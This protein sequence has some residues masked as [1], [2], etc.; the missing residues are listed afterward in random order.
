MNEI[1]I[2][3]KEDI[4]KI[5]FLKDNVLIETYEENL[6][7]TMIEDNIYIGKVQNVFKGMQAAFVNIGVG[8]NVFI[9]LKDLLP[10]VDVVKNNVE[11]IDRPI[12][13][14]IR[15]GQPIIVQVMKDASNKKGARVT[16]HIS[17]KGRYIMY[18]PE[19]EFITASQKLSDD[20]KNRLKL[21]VSETLNENDGAIIRTAAK[22]VSE[23]VLKKEIISLSNKWEEIK[24]VETDSY[25]KLIYDAGGILG[26]YLTDIV[27]K[28][29]DKIIV[30]NEEML[31][32][33][34]NILNGIN[35]KIDIE[36]NEN[37]LDQSGLEKQLMRAQN[38]KVWLDSGGFI[39]IDKTEALIA[40]DVN[41][42]KCMGKD[43][44]EQ[45]IFEINKEAT[46]EIAKQL[47]L[48]DLGGIIIIDYIDMHIEENRKKIIELLEK[49]TKKDIS[50]V[51]I[52]GFSKLNLLELT[53]KHV[54]S[55]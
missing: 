28:G 26:K 40:I 53:R 24:N 10:K 27:D 4:I 45:T 52:E 25:P 14:F 9:H 51:Q 12:T 30:N 8:K 6:K 47:R 19:G 22:D 3:K 15:P 49:E 23:E 41:S 35:A 31:D 7:K 37:L 43:N 5:F 33:V 36:I 39:T 21:I 18:M 48:R 44:F 55:K 34:I 38:R 17:I 42:G 54:Y 1:L 29:I 11:K 20:D 46:I 2:E 16:C 32:K 50:K 13:D